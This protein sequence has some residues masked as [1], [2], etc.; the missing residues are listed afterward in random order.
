MARNICSTEVD[1]G[2][3]GHYGHKVP[4]RQDLNGL[5]AA[6]MRGKATMG[7]I[8]P[9]LSRRVPGLKWVAARECSQHPVL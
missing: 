9:Q 1:P 2:R 3:G 8:C 4:S 5:L 7:Q 6:F